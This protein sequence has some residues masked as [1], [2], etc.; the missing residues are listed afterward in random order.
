MAFVNYKC[1]FVE[2]LELASSEPR[3]LSGADGEDLAKDIQVHC[4]LE[5]N[6]G[7]TLC[8][9]VPIVVGA[10]HAGEDFKGTYSRR[11]GSFLL[12]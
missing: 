6:E 8:G 10:V 4:V 5:A 12:L 3:N 7:W 2:A 9:L 11:T 1:V